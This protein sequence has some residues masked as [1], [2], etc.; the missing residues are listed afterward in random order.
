MHQRAGLVIEAN[1]PPADGLVVAMGAPLP[2]G[3]VEVVC[4][5]VDVTDR[6]DRFGFT[7]GT[8]PIH[9]EQGE[10]S[11]TVMHAPGGIVTFEIVAVLRPRH[12]LSRAFPPIAR[13]LQRAATNRYLMRCKPRSWQARRDEP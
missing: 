13:R 6:P 2:V 10:E 4:R 8:L 3:F 9:P 1:G 12:P 5:V 11:F 7:Y